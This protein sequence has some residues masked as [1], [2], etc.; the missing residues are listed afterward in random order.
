MVTSQGNTA[1]ARSVMRMPR[2]HRGHIQIEADRRV[3]EA[4]LHVDVDDDAEM[5]RIDAEPHRR[6]I[7][8]R[9]HDQDDR[10]RL[11]EIAGHQQQDLTSNRKPTQP[12]FCAMIQ[13]ASADGMFSLVRTNENNTALVMM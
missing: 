2:D 12:R 4:D 1:M 5:H 6:R 3:A 9:R 11:H 13:S 8:D 10:S 7:Q